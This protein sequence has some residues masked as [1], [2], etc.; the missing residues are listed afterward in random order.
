MTGMELIKLSMWL[1]MFQ[2]Q[3]VHPKAV[4]YIA[5]DAIDFSV[6]GWV[7]AM[8]SG[9]FTAKRHPLVPESHGKGVLQTRPT[10]LQDFVVYQNSSLFREACRLSNCCL[11]MPSCLFTAGKTQQS[12]FAACAQISGLGLAGSWKGMLGNKMQIAIPAF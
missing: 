10:S 12:N 2:H 1:L 11:S 4:W 3:E 8:A 6:R 7:G 9:G 5:R